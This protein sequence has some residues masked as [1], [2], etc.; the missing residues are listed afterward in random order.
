MHAWV[1]VYRPDFG[2]VGLD[3]THGHYTDDRYVPVGYGRD[4]DYVRPIRGVV[5]GATTQSQASHLQMQQQQ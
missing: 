2:W 4:Y 3:A 1:E 5:G